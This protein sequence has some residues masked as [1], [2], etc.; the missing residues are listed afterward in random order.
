MADTDSKLPKKMSWMTSFYETPGNSQESR[1]RTFVK[2]QFDYLNDFSESQLSELE[3]S[4]TLLKGVVTSAH[5][6]SI[7]DSGISLPV[8]NSN[9]LEFKAGTAPSFNGTAIPDVVWKSATTTATEPSL[10]AAAITSFA[11]PSGLEADGILPA[12]LGTP[13]DIVEV[14][15]DKALV[16]VISSPT[17]YSSTGPSDVSGCTESIDTLSLPVF[18]D[19]LAAAYT[20]MGLND[21]DFVTGAPS[22][23]SISWTTGVEGLSADFVLKLTDWISGTTNF[24]SAQTRDEIFNAAATR[25]EQKKTRS[26][27]EATSRAAARGFS[28]PPGFLV[29]REAEI[30]GEYA[31]ALADISAKL[32]EKEADLVQQA[33]IEASRI[34]SGY[35]QACLEFTAKKNSVIVENAK[36]EYAAWEAEIKAQLEEND[37][38]VRAFSV[39]VDAYVKQHAG[40]DDKINAFLAEI[41]KSKVS[42][43]AGATNA[44]ILKAKNDA[45]LAS[46]QKIKVELETRKLEGDEYQLD[47]AQKKLKIE[48]EQANADIAAKY[49]NVDIERGKLAIAYNNLE[50]ANEGINV[51][52][53]KIAASVYDTTVKKIAGELEINKY[54]AQVYQSDADIYK[55]DA[56]VYESDIRLYAAV[57][58]A[59]K[60]YVDGVKAKASIKLEEAKLELDNFKAKTEAQTAEEELTIKAILGNLSFTST[61]I[62]AEV[63]TRTELVAAGLSG[64]H[65]QASVGASYGVSN[66]VGYNYG[67]TEGYSESFDKELSVSTDI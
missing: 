44:E 19:A 5:S 62:D 16:T 40:N 50:L 58:D 66:S 35:I 21:I 42:V 63:K 39:A 65:V 6:V 14:V 49:A 7:D 60:A 51:E 45:F 29:A 59:Y 64:V 9:I 37:L 17:S 46:L 61:V 1:A 30:E 53:D 25:V 54:V 3:N 20:K 11:T 34:A 15:A 32:A 33:T 48:Y 10:D 26:L 47:L 41:E 8:I 43:S 38:L 23:A 28:S 24:I 22:P 2:D 13:A 12:A 52:S 56:N 4:L 27:I 36:Q 31:A 18:A 55:A 57:S 67:Y